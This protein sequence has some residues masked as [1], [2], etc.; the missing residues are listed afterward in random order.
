VSGEGLEEII[1]SKTATEEAKVK[2]TLL[3][4]LRV[5][6]PEIQINIGVD[7]TK[8]PE[9]NIPQVQ[10]SIEGI[11]VLAFYYKVA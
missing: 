6:V 5:D 1:V 2:C 4:K 11:P 7:E 9:Q 3:E 10:I 8:L